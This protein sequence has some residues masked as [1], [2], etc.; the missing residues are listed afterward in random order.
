MTQLTWLVT[1]CSSGIGEEFIK[2]VLARGDK[3]IATCRGSTSRISKLAELGAKT[4]TLDVS[5]P[6]DDIKATVAKILEENETIDV[7]VNNAGYGEAGM[8][9]EIK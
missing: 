2:N 4:Y 8:A 6:A 1:G 5:A 7:L 3:A 9:E